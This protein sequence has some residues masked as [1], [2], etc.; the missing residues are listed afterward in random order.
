MN[1]LYNFQNWISE[2]KDIN[3]SLWLSGLTKKDPSLFDI[4]DEYIGDK[5]PT[6][7]LENLLDTLDPGQKK[8]L[9]SRV[10]AKISSDS[11]KAVT[12]SIQSIDPP[13]Q[14]T[15]FKLLIKTLSFLD[16]VVVEKVPKG[17]WLIYFTTKKIWREKLANLS[18]RIT[19][20]NGYIEKIP[21]DQKWVKAFWGVKNDGLF[22]YGFYTK[23]E[24]YPIQEVKFNS[25]FCR[26]ISGLGSRLLW[27]IKRDFMEVTP[28]KLSLLMKI[29]SSVDGFDF[30]SSD[31][32][33]L[34]AKHLLHFGWYGLGI[35]DGQKIDPSSF[36]K[37]KEEIKERLKSYRWSDKIKISLVANEFWIHLY[38]QIKQ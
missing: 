31:K 36:A 37:I 30:P 32:F 28:D 8:E 12:T 23:E 29:K 7:D 20:I 24:F 22:C 2:S 25:N 9:R 34:Y 35:W 11:Q 5:D 26:Y 15:L 16:D 13:R 10:E 27:E 21:G 19:S 1:K 6:I 38:I 18:T 4:V 3:F 17:D 33:S 14:K